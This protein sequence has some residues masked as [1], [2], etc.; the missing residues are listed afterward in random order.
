MSGRPSKP[1]CHACGHLV[2]YHR[3]PRCLGS[4]KHAVGVFVSNDDRCDCTLS[5]EQ[6]DEKKETPR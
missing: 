4:K 1:H 6:A 3:G 5:P 2:A